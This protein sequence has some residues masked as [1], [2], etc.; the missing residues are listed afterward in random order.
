LGNRGCSHDLYYFE[1]G[2]WTPDKE[3]KVKE[4]QETLGLFID[5]KVTKRESLEAEYPTR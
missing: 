3:L 5:G 4:I 2:E 1:P